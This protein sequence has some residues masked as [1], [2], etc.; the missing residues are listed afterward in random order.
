MGKKKVE[1]LKEINLVERTNVPIGSIEPNPWNPNVQDAEIFRVLAQSMKEEGFGEPI[2][3]R[4]LPNGKLQITN[5]EHRYRLA[6][7]TGMTHVPVA[8]V[9][10]SEIDAKL[11]T[12]RRNR[13]RGGL[14][15]IKVAT[16]MRDMRK[17]MSEDEIQLRLG[18]TPDELNE[19]MTMLNN[20]FIPFGGGSKGMPEQYELEVNQEAARFLDDSLITLAGKREKRF[21]GRPARKA[22]GLVKAL[23]AVLGITIPEEVNAPE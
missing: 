8:I 23:E 11:A 14:D 5:G 21:E 13:T 6:L 15:T 7:E 19:M 17:R 18:Y 1:E 3:V 20:P 12:I 22:R 9:D 10:M 4:K 16:I 2:L